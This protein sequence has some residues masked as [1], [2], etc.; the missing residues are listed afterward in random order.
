MRDALYCPNCRVPMTPQTLDTVGLQRSVDVDRCDPCT[1]F[2]F[3][4]TEDMRLA[5]H[6]VIELFQ[7][8][9]HAGKA[10]NALASSCGCPRCDRTLLFTHDLQRAT[11]FTY[12]RCA[13]GHGK[14]ITFHQFLAEKN[15][16]RPPSPQE[17]ERLR[18]TI[19][20]VS[21]SQCGAPIDLRKDSA[22]PH[23]GTPVALI[24][25]QSVARTLRELEAS[26]AAPAS[27]VT[28]TALD[29]AQ[30]DALFDL[31]RMREQDRQPD[32]LAVGVAALA[33]VSG[34]WL[35]SR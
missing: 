9:G 21:C 8:I 30:I 7:A 27:S 24:D 35:A 16:L 22:C 13:Q 29:D 4:A 5:P 31:A 15:F 14:L 28:P 11:R 17:L 2:W 1:V 10:R 26:P 6:A 19:R 23:C 33:S 34:G 25:S 12:W 18:A 20:Q 32:V 3:D